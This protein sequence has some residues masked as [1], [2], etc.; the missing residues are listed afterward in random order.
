[1]C[2]VLCINLEVKE[3]EKIEQKLGVGVCRVK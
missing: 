1:M 3:C 2:K